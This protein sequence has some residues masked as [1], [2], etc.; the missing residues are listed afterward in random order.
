MSSLVDRLIWRHEN[1]LHNLSE[2]G[3]QHSADV[4]TAPCITKRK[5]PLAGTVRDP[6]DQ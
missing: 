6:D 4:A 2:H 5:H 1:L 3:L